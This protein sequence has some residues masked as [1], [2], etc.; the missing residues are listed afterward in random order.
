M[1]PV[2]LSHKCPKGVDHVG[3]RLDV[4]LFTGSAH[5]QHQARFQEQNWINS[6]RA[7]ATAS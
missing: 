1:M 6:M 5:L 2:N 4:M 7:L 3:V